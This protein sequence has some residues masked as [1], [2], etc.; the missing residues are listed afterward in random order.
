MKR[1]KLSK[2]AILGVCFVVGC[3]VVSG[4]ALAIMRPLSTNCVD[5]CRKIYTNC[6][7]NAGGNLDAQKRC[8]KNLNDCVGGCR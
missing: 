7:N 1:I 6:S 8:S 3:V 5:T 2:K 4:N